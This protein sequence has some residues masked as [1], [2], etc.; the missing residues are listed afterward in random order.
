[1]LIVVSNQEKISGSVTC[2]KSVTFEQKKMKKNELEITNEKK[3]EMASI[4]ECKN[5]F[6]ALRCRKGTMNA[7]PGINM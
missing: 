3:I 1:M 2:E 6:N 7:V 5:F 4:I